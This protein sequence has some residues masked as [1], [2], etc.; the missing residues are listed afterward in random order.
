MTTE[1]EFNDIRP[2][3]DEEYSSAIEKL[4]SSDK[5]K[6]LEPYLSVGTKG[7]D[8]KEVLMKIKS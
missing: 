1:Q 2:F 8:T 6:M 7:K 3:N 5:F 4:I